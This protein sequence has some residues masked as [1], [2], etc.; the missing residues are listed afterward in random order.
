MDRHVTKRMSYDSDVTLFLQP[1]TCS[2]ILIAEWTYGGTF[3]K[4]SLASEVDE[5]HTGESFLAV[6][7][8]NGVCW[9]AFYQNKH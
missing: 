8:L 9:L 5:W 6:L 2:I 4:V 7:L 3:I 1:L